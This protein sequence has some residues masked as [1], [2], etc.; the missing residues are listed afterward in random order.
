ME[1]EVRHV[2]GGVEHRGAFACQAPNAQQIGSIGQYLHSHHGVIDSQ[3]GLYIASQ[4]IVFPE[5]QQARF[6]HRGVELLRY[7]ELGG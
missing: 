1:T 7:L 6:A 2:E 5:D 3:D 4:G